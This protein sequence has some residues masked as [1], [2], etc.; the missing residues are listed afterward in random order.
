MNSGG[1]ADLEYRRDHGGNAETSAG[2]PPTTVIEDNLQ[3]PMPDGTS[4]EGAS[5][6]KAID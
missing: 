3:I 2:Y 5:T 6:Q 4:I 1:I